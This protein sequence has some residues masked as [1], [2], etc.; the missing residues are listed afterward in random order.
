LPQPLD[1]YARP[2]G[3]GAITRKRKGTGMQSERKSERK[4][5]VITD[6]TITISVEEFKRLTGLGHTTVFKMIKA[7]EIETV[8]VR[9]RRLIIFA[10]VKKLVTP[11]VAIA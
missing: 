8:K 11:E 7:N 10:S 1:L 5:R 2:S 9:D 6:D 3:I 4:P